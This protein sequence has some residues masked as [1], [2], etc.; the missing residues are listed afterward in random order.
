MSEATE[1]RDFFLIA[2]DMVLDTPSGAARVVY[3]GWQ[4]ATA[5]QIY[6]ELRERRIASD[7]G[8]A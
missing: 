3:G 5:G 8:T 4:H 7:G 1:N 6:D 2:A